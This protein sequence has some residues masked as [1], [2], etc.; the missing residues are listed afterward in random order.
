MFKTIKVK[1]KLF[2]IVDVYEIIAI[3]ALYDGQTGVYLSEG[4]VLEVPTNIIDI[5]KQL[6]L[7]EI[8]NV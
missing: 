6:K 1:G 3:K 2:A 7:E 8:D 5:N 4:V